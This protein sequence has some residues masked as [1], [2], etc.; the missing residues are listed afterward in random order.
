MTNGI[1][2][3]VA[4]VAFA[5]IFI[6]LNV[7]RDRSYHAVVVTKSKHDERLERIAQLERELGISDGD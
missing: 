6:F 7:Y 4:L 3:F 1:L 5:V 2:G